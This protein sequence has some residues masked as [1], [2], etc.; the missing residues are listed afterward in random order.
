MNQAACSS[1]E[2][3][4][5]ITKAASRQT[6]TTIRC[7]A[8]RER[9]ADAF[10]AYGYFRWVDDIVD[11]EAGEQSEKIAFIQRQKCVLEAC[12]RGEVYGA[13]C[14]EERMLVDLVHNDTEPNSGLQIY[15]RNMID[16]MLFDA[17][18]RG[19]V[20][21]REQLS[22]YS[23][24]LAMAVTEA[25]Y[26]FIGHHDPSPPYHE[27]RYLAVTAAHIVHMLR[28]A[29]ED[30]DSGYF[31]IPVEILNL[32]GISPGDIDS[33]AYREWVCERVQLAHDLFAG[34]RKCT[35]RVKNWRCRLAG[36]AY[37]ARFEWMLRVIERDRYCLR[38]N[39]PE[40][41]SLAAGLWMGGYTLLSMLPAA[42]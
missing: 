34:G 25:I 41:K 32:N 1:Q 5:A 7:F 33:R 28:D 6:Y 4:A 35:A 29:L 36:Y 42:L 17:S 9:M 11:A 16:V 19:Q 30:V 31:N 37:I 12:Y 26:Y 20:I 39:Y 38:S 2:L 40:R 24:K 15:L 27:G 18:R 10:R 21:T 23:H 13:L 8:D 14:P 22:E 3:A